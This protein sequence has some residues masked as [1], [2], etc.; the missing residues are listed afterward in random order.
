MLIAS[1]LIL[2]VR[3]AKWAPR[4]FGETTSDRDVEVD[5]AILLAGRVFGA[6]VGRHETLFPQ[7]REAWFMP[8]DEDVPK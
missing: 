6:L 1:C 7:K 4:A 5:N 8:N 2:A 3:T